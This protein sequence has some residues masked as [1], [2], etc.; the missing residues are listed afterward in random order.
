MPSDI[1]DLRRELDIVDVISEYIN[2]QRVGSNYRANCPFHPDR[3]PSFYVSPSRQIFKCFG[4]GVGGDAI[5]FVSLYENLS[6]IE[7]A[8]HLARRY[9]ISLRIKGEKEGPKEVYDALE[10][11][12]Q[13]YHKKLKE[14]RE[15]LEYLKSRGIDNSS[16]RRF[17]LGYSPSSQE[18]VEFLKRLG[19]L[20]DYEKTGNLVRF[21]DGAYRDLF[22]N[23]L[24]IPIR[25]ARGRVVGF[26]GRILQGEGPKYVNSPDSDIF[27]KR[28]LL[29]GLY[30]GLAYLKDLKTAIVVEGYFDVIAL[31]QEGFRNAVATLGT[32]FGRDHALQLSKFVEK[33]FLV[34]DGDSAGRKA[35]RLAVP[36]LLKAGLEVY[37]L[38]LPEGTDPHDFIFSRGKEAFRRLLDNSRSLFEQLLYRIREGVNP[39]EAIRDFTY[40]VSFLK[41]EVEAYSLLAQLSKLT[42]IPVDVLAS[43]MYRREEPSVEE[44]DPRVSF[45]EKLFLKGLFELRPEINIEELNLS[46]KAYELAK[47]ILA[48]EYYHIPEEILNLKVDDLE[49]AFWSS[50]DKLRIDIPEEELKAQ[51]ASVR[52]FVREAMRNHRGGIKPA[53]ARRWRGKLE[54]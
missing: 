43:K 45:T 19:L 3:T 47:S 48:E 11:V 18:L 8:K 42:K 32:S 13:F 22:R 35:L 20:K 29:F 28:E 40:F 50:V 27:K 15:P 52:E 46:S 49:T 24:I 37:P 39:E 12:S 36:H 33:V 41:D 14:S 6:Y 51:T 10:A 31:H 23:R 21:S 4:C 44:E 25:D 7:A 38:Y 17:N 9:G 54:S 30:E 26:G 5:K 34:F 2:L 53:S 1:D 16:V